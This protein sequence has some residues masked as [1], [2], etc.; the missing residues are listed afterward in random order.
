MKNDSNPLSYLKRDEVGMFAV[1]K[2]GHDRGHLY[3]IIDQEP[4]CVY[5]ADGRLRMMEQPKRKNRKHIQ[6]I[7]QKVEE[8]ILSN[9]LN[10][11]KV[12]NE[13]IKRAIR[14]YELDKI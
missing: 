12:E 8:G 10:G 5:L 2:S 14:L 13:K 1:S 6:I 4:G 11:K 7:H 3:V 9:L